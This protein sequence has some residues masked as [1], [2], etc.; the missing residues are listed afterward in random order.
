MQIR[1]NILLL[2]LIIS[3][4]TGSAT[5][6]SDREK[7]Q[8]WSEQIVDGLL[9]G[10]A[11]ELKAG[12]TTFLGIFTEA[13]D[14]PSDRAVIL[15][16]G[17]GVHPDWPEVINPLR[18]TLPDNGWST[19]SVQMPILANDAAVADYAP[20]FD[21]VAPRVDASIKYLQEKGHKTI[22]LLGHSLGASMGATYLAGGN[23]QQIKGLVAIGMS[24]I[25]NNDKMNSALALQTIRIPVLDIY[26]S[27]DLETVLDSVK[28]RARSARMAKNPDYQQI[29]IEG[30]DHFFVGVENSLHRRVY[31]WLKSRFDQ[32]PR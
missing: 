3:S 1:I 31:G 5:A 32:P 27:R 4:F 21:E 9:V 7:E 6:A 17:I 12:E 2:M 23:K 15:L 8:R 29:Q 13:S 25:E 24:V 19:L 22:V 16:H 18:S 14:G 11:V 30:A 10:E 26:G 20:L 28:L